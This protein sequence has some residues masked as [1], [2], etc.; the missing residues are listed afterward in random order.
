MSK[1]DINEWYHKNYNFIDWT[2]KDKTYWKS[3]FKHV[4]KECFYKKN[5]TF[6]EEQTELQSW[7]YA[8]TRTTTVVKYRTRFLS[9][10]KYIK[11][12]R[13]IH[14]IPRVKKNSY[15]PIVDKWL[16]LQME[17]NF[18]NLDYVDNQRQ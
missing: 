9:P 17:S 5:E 6:Y 14:R 13:N 15:G 10:H 1:V 12:Q 7:N 8:S 3:I 16:S 4:N 2:S 18:K 11:L